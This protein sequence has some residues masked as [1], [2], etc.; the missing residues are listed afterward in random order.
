MRKLNSERFIE[1]TSVPAFVNSMRIEQED[2]QAIIKDKEG[3]TVLL[4]WEDD[5]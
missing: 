4:Y 5:E 1:P 2:I 3:N